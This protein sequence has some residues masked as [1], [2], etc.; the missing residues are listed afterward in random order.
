MI[1]A[2]LYSLYSKRAAE[3]GVV[4]FGASDEPISDEQQRRSGTKLVHVPTTVGAVVFAFDVPGRHPGAAR[5]TSPRFP[6]GVGAKGNEG[7]TA[8]I[9]ATPMSIGYVELEHARQ[10]EL[11][12]ATVKDPAGTSSLRR[13][14]PSN[15]LRRACPRPPRRPMRRWC[16][17][18]PP[19]KAHVPSPRCLSW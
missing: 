5:L 18:T 14:M 16:C 2:H 1:R 10:S 11:A 4:D 9:K 7:V 6:V 8:L 13:S 15:V 19:T 17:S 3:Y 12:T